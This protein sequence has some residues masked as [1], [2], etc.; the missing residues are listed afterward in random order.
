M[1]SN[2][3]DVDT[4]EFEDNSEFS[5]DSDDNDTASRHE[6]DIQ[7]SPIQGQ[8]IQTESV[9]FQFLFQP[10]SKLSAEKDG[11]GQERTHFRTF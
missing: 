9:S 8:I 11:G 7:V 5:P 3:S 1:A 4:S 2:S 10:T 6:D